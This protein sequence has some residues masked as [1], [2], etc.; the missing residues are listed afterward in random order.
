MLFLAFPNKLVKEGSKQDSG[1]SMSPPQGAVGSVIAEGE[2]A[3]P[4]G[5]WADINSH[6]TKP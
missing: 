4:V 5:D 3:R 1:M 6:R 2:A